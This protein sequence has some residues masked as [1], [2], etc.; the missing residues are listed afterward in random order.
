MGVLAA[1]LIAYVGLVAYAARY[2][3]LAEEDPDKPIEALPQAGPT[4]KA[5]LHFLLPVV[6]LVWCLMVEL[7]SPGLSAFYA[8]ALMIVIVITQRP[9]I[10][11]FRGHGEHG[12]AWR[13]GLLDLRD[14]LA[15]GGRNMIGIAVATA[16]AGIVVGTVTLT[17][18][19][20]KLTEFVEFISGGHLFLMLVLTA[21]ISLILGM[22]L[23]TT[24]NY[25][26][27]ATLMAP[28]IVELG[29]Q[30]GLIVPLIAVHMFVFYFGIMADVTPPVGLASF[31]AAAISGADPMQD[32]PRRLVLQPAHR[33]PAVPVHLQH[34]A[35][36]DRHRQLAPPGA[37]GDHRDGR[38]A[39][40][41]RRDHELVPDQE[42]ALGERGAAAGRLHAVPPGL[43]LGPALSAL[44]EVDPAAI[45]Q[46]AEAV[47]AGGDLR[48]A[49]R[50]PLDRGRRGRQGGDAAD[51][52]GRARR[53][54][55]ARRRARAAQRGGPG[56]HRHD[57]LRQRGGEG[58][59]RLRLR[60]HRRA[61]A[62][63]RPPKELMWLPALLLLG[64]IVW[65]Q[66]RRQPAAPAPRAAPV[67]AGED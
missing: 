36:A 64:L 27:V 15:T 51:G 38:D 50:G 34:P 2:P 41:R 25:I 35:A 12:A 4:F 48:L 26:V 10:A 22:G 59:P 37:A 17:G 8:T 21:V 60:D 52:A 18:V 33:G 23:P 66:R 13:H 24:A 56:V 11:W 57:R 54:A 3:D 63:E 20:L 32:R 28:V 46:A 58:R 5:G 42:P 9:L 53:R 19:G 1:P 30:S 44:I 39:G 43:L 45:E 67:A 6:V 7:L 47:P 31:A 29:A 62:S 49:G 61:P 16:T 55:P 65:L 40:L 14:G